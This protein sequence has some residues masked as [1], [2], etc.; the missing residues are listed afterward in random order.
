MSC[1]ETKKNPGSTDQSFTG[2]RPTER[3][4]VDRQ[5]EYTPGTGKP[6]PAP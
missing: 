6:H 1:T 4:P 5:V 3:S 2:V